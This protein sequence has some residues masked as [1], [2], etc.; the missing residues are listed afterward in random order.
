MAPSI[1]ERV[2]IASNFLNNVMMERRLKTLSRGLA[3]AVPS[4]NTRVVQFIHQSVK[5]FFVE[6][7]L[8]FLDSSPNSGEAKTFGADLEGWGLVCLE[9][10]GDI[11]CGVILRDR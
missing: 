5:D 10:K 7:G 4:S 1:A 11:D 8:S 9:M 3:E 6:K 2:A